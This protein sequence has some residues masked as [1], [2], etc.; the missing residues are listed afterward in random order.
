MRAFGLSHVGF[1]IFIIPLK[2]PNSRK[3]NTKFAKTLE[4][5][6][7]YIIK[8]FTGQPSLFCLTFKQVNITI[9]VAFSPSRF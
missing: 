1:I 7:H 8:L 2:K 5:L 4:P 3:E 9:Q 6:N